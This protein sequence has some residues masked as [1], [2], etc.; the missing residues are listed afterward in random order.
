MDKTTIECPNCKG[1]IVITDT[2]F[3]ECHECGKRYKNP[4]YVKN[5]E[6]ATAENAEA[7]QE[8][9][10]AQAPEEPA[11]EE[12]VAQPTEEP[13]ADVAIE[14]APTQDEPADPT[15]EEE[16]KK[17]AAKA[18]RGD[19]VDVIR[20]TVKEFFAFKQYKRIPVGLAVCA[21]ILLSPF[22][23]TVI[24]MIPSFYILLF[25]YKL[26]SSP[27]D[28]L[29]NGIRSESDSV[30]IQVVLYLVGYPLIFIIKF[31]LAMFGMVFFTMYFFFMLFA[32]VYGWGGIKFQP[33]LFDASTDCSA[34]LVGKA[35]NKTV[36]SL[37]VVCIL[38]AVLILGL[39][40]GLGIDPSDFERPSNPSY[41]DGY[42]NGYNSSY[43]S[44][45]EDSTKYLN[46]Y[47]GTSG[48]K[49]YSFS[50]SSSNYYSFQISNNYGYANV[51]VTV[52]NTT[53]FSTYNTSKSSSVYL[54]SGY[55]YTVVVS[56]SNSDSYNTINFKVTSY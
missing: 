44:L 17:K 33:F 12:P 1:T 30:P 49:T 53:V 36:I 48:S 27:V 26:L 41:N 16:P 8:Q 56:W 25:M 13:V 11:V 3:L 4:F 29:L 38:I 31:A 15:P 5:D 52:D 47:E 54:Y 45:Y 46:V 24:F 10:V 28:Y 23:L 37:L 14:D 50:P 35:S 34:H 7:A 18:D 22:L 42:N 19:F 32:Y 51:T 39:G 2:E 6:P 40:F 43:P 55:T 20:N 9:P 21:G